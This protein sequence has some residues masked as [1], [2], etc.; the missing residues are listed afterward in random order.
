MQLFKTIL[1]IIIF[2]I[3]IHAQNNYSPLVG[4]WE[5]QSL[6]I[7]YFSEPIEKEEIK[8]NNK[9]YESIVFLPSGQFS[10]QGK[11]DGEELIGN[12]TYEIN[13]KKLTTR[14]NNIN[15]LTEFS[16]NGEILTINKYEKESDDFYAMKT[17][18]IYKKE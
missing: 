7:D 5:F 15:T 1:L 3:F 16:I 17:V 10:F 8:K 11:S 6:S 12:G 14:V 13:G 4:R 2:S 18:F 9:Y